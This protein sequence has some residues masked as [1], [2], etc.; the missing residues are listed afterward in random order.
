MMNR[1]KA[2]YKFGKSWADRRRV[3]KA[4]GEFTD[5]RF[6]QAERGLSV[7]LLARRARGNPPDDE[8]AQMAMDWLIMYMDRSNRDA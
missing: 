7:A 1:S 4:S 8:V 3:L 6:N 5:A 2:A